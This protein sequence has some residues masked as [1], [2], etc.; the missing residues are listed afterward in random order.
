MV[1]LPTS[2]LEQGFLF[3]HGMLKAASCRGEDMRRGVAGE[4]WVR[5]VPGAAVSLAAA[6]GRKDGSRSQSVPGFVTVSE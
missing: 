6:G 3:F 5:T 4:P 2:L 1:Y